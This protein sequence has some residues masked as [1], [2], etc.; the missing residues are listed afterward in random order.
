MTDVPD[1]VAWMRQ[2]RRFNIAITG[3]GFADDRLEEYFEDEPA[4]IIAP[5]IQFEDFLRLL[6][7][8]G[9]RTMLP[10]QFDSGFKEYRVN[11]GQQ[12]YVFRIWNPGRPPG[13]NEKGNTQRI[14]KTST[15]NN[16]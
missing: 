1:R 10:K 4:W 13:K 9:L 8:I 6:G 5:V 15:T 2:N 16:K 11:E 7:F 12:R 14:P 3:P